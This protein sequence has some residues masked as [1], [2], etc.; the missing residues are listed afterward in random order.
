MS[1]RRHFLLWTAFIAVAFGGYHLIQPSR[2]RERDVGLL[3]Q[4]LTPADLSQ[5][6]GT[7]DR[8]LTGRLV[9]NDGIRD[10]H[11]V[12]SSG[13]RLIFRF[14]RDA[15]SDSGWSGFG[16]WTNISDP[17][18]IGDAV[19]DADV[20]QHLPCL[21]NTPAAIAASGMLRS[22]RLRSAPQLDSSPPLLAMA[23]LLPPQSSQV[24]VVR[25]GPTVPIVPPMPPLID[26]MP[27]PRLDPPI[28]LTT[29]PISFSPQRLSRV[30]PYERSS[31]S[32]R[33]SGEPSD[34]PEPPEPPPAPSP[35]VLLV[36]C[37]GFTD[38]TKKACELIDS[39]VLVK[40]LNES[41]HMPNPM[42]RLDD[43]VTKLTGRDFRIIQLPALL[44]DRDEVIKEIFRI[45]I[46]TVNMVSIR[47][48]HDVAKLRPFKWD[49]PAEQERKLAAVRADVKQVRGIWQQ[50][51]EESRPSRSM[52]SSSTQTSDGDAQSS[53]D[54]NSHYRIHMNDNS[55][56]RQAIIV[57][58]TN[59]K[60]L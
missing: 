35:R 8:D 30:V 19:D 6:C 53:S 2:A 27:F 26:P 40:D 55:A 58:D 36:P 23:V 24:P 42:G 20:V 52:S 56:L 45:E 10:I 60:G 33:T 34:P 3:I 5:A 43:L 7:P 16:V 14:L 50:A 13:R 32:S 57:R 47:L 15:D 11:Y 49:T 4:D 9:A 1:V 21:A 59:W 31:T 38:S 48:Q 17:D 12:D 39:A 28:P 44:A 54:E 41:L 51:I 37:V 29:P 18:G 46:E 22:A 25:P